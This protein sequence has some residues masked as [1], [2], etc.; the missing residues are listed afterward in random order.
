MFVE[1]QLT[2]NV[3]ALPNCFSVHIIFPG[4]KGWL[5]LIQTSLGGG[6]VVFVLR[7]VVE[8]LICRRL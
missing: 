2:N 4:V 1:S 3:M 8:K 7:R 5:S 6:V